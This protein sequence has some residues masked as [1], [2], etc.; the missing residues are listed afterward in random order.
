MAPVTLPKKDVV[1]PLPQPVVAQ[2]TTAIP[3]GETRTTGYSPQSSFEPARVSPSSFDGQVR[4]MQPRAVDADL[5]RLSQAAYN[6]SVQQVGKWTRVSDEQLRKDG[7]DPAMLQNSTSGFKAA[8]FTDPQG[9]HVVAFAG[10]DTKNKVDLLK[11]AVTD[12]GQGLGVPFSGQYRQAVDLARQANQAYGGKVVMTGH[13]LGGGLAATAAMATGHSAV[14]FNAAGVHND[15]LLSVGLNPLS[16]KLQAASGQ[17]RAYSVAGEVLTT[18]QVA[19]PG[20]PDAMGTPILLKDPKPPKLQPTW[21]P[22]EMGR[23]LVQ[24]EKD[25]AMR[26]FQLHGSDSVIAALDQQKPW[27]A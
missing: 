18:T 12:V 19:S 25:T 22:V 26:P 1:Q 15:T 4:G 5:M 10:T 23:R 2:P 24:F 16:T 7:I 11:D 9:N 27:A 8:V 17:V 20:L 3:P 13:S 14:T 21:N 6:P